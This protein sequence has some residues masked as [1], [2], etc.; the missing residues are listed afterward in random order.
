MFITLARYPTLTFH[1]HQDRIGRPSTW[2]VDEII[3]V[4]GLNW[5]S[6]AREKWADLVETYSRKGELS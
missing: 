3:R 4:A 2:S 1:I 6:L 5:A